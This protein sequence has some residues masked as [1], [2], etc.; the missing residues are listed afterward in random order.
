MKVEL[1]VKL[2]GKHVDFYS[3]T[4][5]SAVSSCIYFSTSFG[6]ICHGSGLFHSTH[7]QLCTCIFYPIMYLDILSDYVLGYFIRLCTWIFYLKI[8][9]WDDLQHVVEM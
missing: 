6:L 2:R 3:K 4:T 7:F 9:E 8:L 5:I 1:N